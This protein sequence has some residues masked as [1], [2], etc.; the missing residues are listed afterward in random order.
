MS[1]FVYLERRSNL[2]NATLLLL[3]HGYNSNEADLFSFS[4]HVP[5]HYH[6]VSLQAPLNLGHGHAWFPIHFEE[7]MERWTAVDEVTTA[8]N[9]V[10]DFLSFYATKNSS[11][12][13]NVVLL[14]FSQGAML[15]YA[16]GF[17]S[18]VVKGIAALSGYLD[19]RFQT[20]ANTNL[21]SIYVS[22]GI[23]DEV[24]PYSWA[25]QSVALLKEKK[26]TPAFYSYPQGHGINQENLMSLIQ[27]LAGKQ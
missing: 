8:I 27:W 20:I 25:Q 21:K 24:V 23:H 16:V 26:C 3:L 9:Y 5:N 12:T 22:H 6:V 7:N 10:N 15:S 4:S 2:P 19:P 13:R 18:A 1:G 14:G 11:D 17:Q